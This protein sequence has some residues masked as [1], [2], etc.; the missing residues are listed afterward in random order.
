MKRKYLGALG[1]LTRGVVARGLVR[2]GIGS[3]KLPFSTARI[4]SLPAQ[5]LERRYQIKKLE[6]KAQRRRRRR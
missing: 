2:A 4:V 5:A 6:R 3:T 1:A